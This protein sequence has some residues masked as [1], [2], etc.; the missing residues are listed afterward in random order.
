[1]VEGGWTPDRYQQWLSQT[2]VESLV[3]A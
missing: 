3:R 1:V 2:L